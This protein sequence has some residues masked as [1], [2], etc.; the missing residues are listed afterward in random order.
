MPSP[1]LLNFEHYLA[2]AGL[3]VKL[4]QKLSQHSPNLAFTWFQ[5]VVTTETNAVDQDNS[6][7]IILEL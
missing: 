3:E 5:K 4:G 1:A 2:L 7:L 6:I